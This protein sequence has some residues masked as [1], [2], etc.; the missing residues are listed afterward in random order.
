MQSWVS[1]SP[2]S[3]F[4]LYNVP[5]GII[6]VMNGRPR[7]AT[8]L[9]DTVIDLAAMAKHGFFDG[10]GIDN[11]VFEQAFL[12]DFIALGKE[13]TSAV[14]KKIQEVFAADNASLQ[15]NQAAIA[16]ILHPVSSVQNLMPVYV[17]DYTDFYSSIEHATNVGIMFRGKEN[18]LMPNWKHLPVGYHGRAS[19]IVVS[20]VDLH[21][22]KG[23]TR[24][25][26]N[27]PPVYGASKQMD[28]ELEMAFIIGKPTELGET[29]SA[30]KAEEYIFGLLLFNDW[31]ARDLQKWEYIPL[32]PF[33]G[34]NF[35]SSVSPWLVTLEALA[36]F[37]VASPTQT[38][39]EVLPYLQCEKGQNIDIQLEVYLQPEHS[40]PTKISTS[41]TKYL[42]WNMAQQLAHHTV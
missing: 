1:I 13:K 12:N 3:D 6:R 2:T 21:R 5:F 34:K 14:R 41:N 24:P 23:Q 11:K 9:G 42:Y 37:R 8:I 29:V 33:L 22:P 38:D 40:E 30:N 27:L 17:R 32:G 35:G 26:D 36:P 39:P 7:V 15:Q 25:D 10:L 31:S 20:G 16:D 28:F 4:S 19:S 18:A